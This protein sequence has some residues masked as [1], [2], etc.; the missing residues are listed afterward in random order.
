MSPDQA[1]LSIVIVNWNTREYLLGALKSIYDAPPD[2]CIQVIVVDNASTDSSAQAVQDAFP[3]VELVASDTNLGYASGNNVGMKLATG[4]YVLLLNPDVE[5]EP[6]ALNRA[7]AIAKTKDKLSALGARQITPEG[8]IQRSVRGF[9]KPASVFYEAIGLSRLFPRSKLF[10]A[11]RMTW[12]DYKS[13]MHVDQPM[14]TFLLIP[15]PVLKEVGLL[16]EQFPIFFNEVDWCYRASLQG[17]VAWYSPEVEL[18]HYGG[19]STR[20]VKPKMAWES[21]RSLLDYYWKH[22]RGIAYLPI[23]WIASAASY[24]QTKIVSSKRAK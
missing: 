18:L 11:Y 16:D 17:Y 13:E 8:T 9:P 24:I 3:Q 20:Q 6:D 2:Y 12:F 21:R 4:D 22:Y 23:F 1:T 19:G 14:G 15:S 7:V 5:L 10:G